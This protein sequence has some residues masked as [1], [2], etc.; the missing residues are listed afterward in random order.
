M[1]KI[2]PGL[3]KCT[4]VF[5]SVLVVNRGS[6]L[7]YEHFVYR[8]AWYKVLMIAPAFTAGFLL[9]HNNGESTSLCCFIF[10]LFFFSIKRSPLYGVVGMLS[11]W[12]SLSRSWEGKPGPSSWQAFYRNTIMD[13]VLPF[14]VIFCFSFLYKRS[15]L[16]RSRHALGIEI[17]LKVL[18][19]KPGP[20]SWPEA[21]QS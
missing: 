21:F 10:N 11:V 9:E 18:R 1:R 20:S 13:K 7:C 15:P 4:E 6:N 3:H 14:V 16:W 8:I 5:S 2:R 17:P 12:R 19:G